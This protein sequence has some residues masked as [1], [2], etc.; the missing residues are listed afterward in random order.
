MEVTVPDVQI[1]VTTVS[2]LRIGMRVRHR[3]PPPGV[4][5]NTRFL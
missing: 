3:N 4:G 2:S 5:V 1:G